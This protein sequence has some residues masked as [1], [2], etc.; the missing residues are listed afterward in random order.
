MNILAIDYGQKRIGLAWVDIDLKVVVPFGVI[1]TRLP[2]G[3]P[4]E[5]MKELIN[6]I[7]RENIGKLVIGLPLGL[8]GKENANTEKIRQVAATLQEQIDIPIEFFDERFSSHQADRTEGGVSRDE[9]A[10]MVILESFLCKP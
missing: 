5:W 1:E 8:D 7:Q 6:L 4:R 2:S 9:K 10:A 3:K